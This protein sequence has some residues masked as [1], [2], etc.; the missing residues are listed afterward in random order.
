MNNYEQIFDKISKDN[1]GV[2]EKINL[3][4]FHKIGEPITSNITGSLAPIFYLFDHIL[5]AD[6]TGLDPKTLEQIRQHFNLD[7]LMNINSTD[8][9]NIGVAKHATIIYKFIS[10]N[11]LYFYYSNTGSGIYNQLLDKDKG[12]TACKIFYITN[13]ELQDK[14]LNFFKSLQKFIKEI[15]KFDTYS[16]KSNIFTGKTDI[17]NMWTSTNANIKN[18]IDDELFNNISN[19]MIFYKNNYKYENY[20]EQV[21]MYI[22]FDYLCKKH[23]E[24]IVE[25]TFNHVLNNHDSK[26]YTDNI[27]KY[28]F[29]IKEINI[30]KYQETNIVKYK[31]IS[32]IKEPEEK[33]EF[34]IFIEEIQ[35][36]LNEI[37]EP[38][39]K[40]KFKNSFNLFFNDISGLY[41]NIQNSGSCTYYC[42]YNLAINMTILR[43]FNECKNID[44]VIESIIKFHFIMIYMFCISYTTDYLI[45]SSKLYNPQNRYTDTGINKLLNDNDKLL[46]KISIYYKHENF[47]FNKNKLLID[48]LLVSKFSGE[49][50][51]PNLQ[52]RV[53][54]NFLFNRLFRFLDSIIFNIR[55]TDPNKLNNIKKVVGTHIYVNIK[56]I[57]IE[58]LTNHK[59]FY[60]KPIQQNI[61]VSDRDSDSDRDYIKLC[62]YFEIIIIYLI[63]LLE[64]YIEKKKISDKPG[65]ARLNKV[66]RLYFSD[67]SNPMDDLFN[68]TNT[69]ELTD[70]FAFDLLLVR[71]NYSE[72]M[73]LSSKI[74][75]NL[76]FIK[77]I[78]EIYSIDFKYKNYIKIIED[79]KR[80]EQQYIYTCFDKRLPNF[81]LAVFSDLNFFKPSKNSNF[82]KAWN[83]RDHEYYKIIILFSRYLVVNQILNDENVLDEIKDKYRNTISSIKTILLKYLCTIKDKEYDFSYHH[84]LK[85]IPI[86]TNNKLILINEN[87]SEGMSSHLIFYQLINKDSIVFHNV[88]FN[89]ETTLEIIDI[90]CKNTDVDYII[91]KILGLLNLDITYIKWLSEFGFIIP[92]NL[93]G[94]VKKDEKSFN[95]FNLPITPST[96]L[97]SFDI[98][99]S[100]FGLIHQDNSE[101]IILYNTGDS[102]YI[103][104]NPPTHF[105]D[106]KGR[107]N[108]CYICLHKIKK[109]IKISYTDSEINLDNCFLITKEKEYKLLFNLNKESH[110]FIYLFPEFSP[111]LCY[112]KDDKFNVEFIISGKFCKD[113]LGKSYI[114]HLKNDKREYS[115]YFYMTS[116]VIAPSLLFPTC[117]SF[118]LEDYKLLFTIYNQ[119]PIII[120]DDKINIKYNSKIDFRNLNLYLNELKEA[121]CKSISCDSSD[122]DKFT[123]IFN[124]EI[125]Y[126]KERVQVLNSFLQDNFFCTNYDSTNINSNISYDKEPSFS[127]KLKLEDHILDNI[128]YHIYNMEKNII[129]KLIKKIKNNPSCWDIQEVLNSI[130]SIIYFNNSIKNDQYFI[131]ELLFLFQCEYFFK[132]NQI[133]K[134][135]EI[136]NEMFNL[137]TDLKLHQFMMGKG[138]TSV[139]TPLLAFGVLFNTCKQPTIITLKHLKN[140]TRKFVNFIEHITNTNVNIYSDYEAKKRWIE[141]SD[142]QLRSRIMKTLNKNKEELKEINKLKNINIKGLIRSLEHQKIILEDIIN[143]NIIR[144]K[145]NSEKESQLKDIIEQIKYLNENKL[146]KKEVEIKILKLTQEISEIENVRIENEINLIDEFDSH[147]NYLQSMFNYIDDKISISNNLFNYIFDFTNSN[148]LG[149]I[150]NIKH[151]VQPDVFKE[152]INKSLKDT[153]GMKYNEH[154]GFEHIILNDKNKKYRICTPFARKDTPILN[155]NFSNII[156]R[157]ILTF[158]IYIKNFNSKLNDEL[159]DFDN[160]KN[161]KLIIIDLLQILKC[162]DDILTRINY[163]ISDA[164]FEIQIIKDL[165]LKL[166]KKIETDFSPNE[167]NNIKNDVLKFYLYKIN[168][169]ILYVSSKQFNM[170]FQ[171]IIYNKYNQWQVG[172][173]GT[174]SLKL[175]FEGSDKLYTFKEIKED[176]DERIEVRL[177][178]E[179]YGKSKYNNNV[180]YIQSFYELRDLASKVLKIKEIFDNETDKPRGIVDLAGIF[181]NYKNK[182]VAEEFN[183]IYTGRKI[184]YLSLDDK[185]IEYD[186]TYKNYIEF[187]NDNFYYYDQCHVVG[188]DLKQPRTGRILII[189]NESTKMTDFAQ[190]IFRFRTLNRGT[191]LN[192]LL[193]KDDATEDNCLFNEDVYKFLIE[194]EEKF[195]RGQ[196]NGLIYQQLKAMIRSESNNYLER[197][198]KP[199]Y[200]R[201]KKIDNESIITYMHDNI[202][203]YDLIKSDLYINNLNAK[204]LLLNTPGNNILIDLVLGNSQNN[205]EST[206]EKSN[207]KSNEKTNEKMVEINFEHDIPELYIPKNLYTIKHL[208]CKLCN[209]LNCVK[210]FK[211]LD[212]KINNKDIYISYNIL[213]INTNLTRDTQRYSDQHETLLYPSGRFCFIEFNDKILIEAEDISL[214]YYINKLPVYNFLGQ[215]LLPNMCNLQNTKNLFLLDINKNFLDLIGLVK[216]VSPFIKTEA[217][218]PMDIVVKD[219]SEIGLVILLCLIKNPGN[220]NRYNISPILYKELKLI[221][222]KLSVGSNIELKTEIVHTHNS[223]Y[224]IENINFHHYNT[225]LGLNKI[226]YDKLP[227]KIINDIVYYYD[228]SKDKEEVDNLINLSFIRCNKFIVNHVKSLSEKEESYNI[229]ITEQV[230][231]YIIEQLKKSK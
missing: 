104:D 114:S 190:A 181:V 52:E 147:H 141:Y 105:I 216:Y 206:N 37:E 10:N 64:N 203:D 32:E 214:D 54:N 59:Q 148:V 57:F 168:Q 182:D 56:E 171:D 60:D 84:L 121:L 225:I 183:K 163:I 21:L 40:Y 36:K 186:R 200:L 90:L 38:I 99:L 208:N 9:I 98:L 20:R 73:M 43:Y 25:C 219:L 61:V 103:N 231:N 91:D 19:F 71:L 109:I 167:C 1:K 92:D 178:L 47:I 211:T 204:L 227:N 82:K 162:P 101:F 70:S 205:I 175:V 77:S 213:K 34:K 53:E 85:I 23:H 189:I 27:K 153:S 48:N 96:G 79:N 12:I 202:I 210:L 191:Y 165:I 137:N 29:S 66:R 107:S 159:F 172:Y 169:D 6:Y 46:D 156:L 179:G 122:R 209:T 150:T 93:N 11:R 151:E 223:E 195:N 86:F 14:Y 222:V 16:K 212:I 35:I 18:F 230:L 17:E 78:T 220:K 133:K 116:Y 138:K 83:E 102:D 185:G 173:T 33:S 111:Y 207:E 146:N 74:K 13:L 126:K 49:L 50:V 149:D 87:V 180:F 112:E 158:N 193:V 45:G 145:S 215:L 177:T 217:I 7:E 28:D 69:R 94:H 144:K 89:Y 65:N 68:I 229:H 42:Y 152:Y 41:N 58:I 123:K 55:N 218:I 228:F 136:R 135:N 120:S 196:T 2:E 128:D 143:E 15:S 67:G 118:N 62:T 139:F 127:N 184:V 132:E 39:F 97:N 95:I 192:I 170:S 106:N 198:I 194:N 199:E 161:N 160:L 164:N 88:V 166:Y 125:T 188:S 131:Y 129:N 155:S 63:L 3:L 154:Y 124:K 140:P 108:E 4:A 117:D 30:E 51:K 22:I 75:I 119:E 72:I 187:H 100:R 5:D 130:K 201:D 157:L 226:N 80:E 174:A 224:N 115:D 134:Y 176:F 44:K 24:Q 142:E 113:K 76:E 31:L 110:P 81:D 221:N 197:D 8:I 26:D